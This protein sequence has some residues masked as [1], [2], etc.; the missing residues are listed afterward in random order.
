MSPHV[1]L[2]GILRP[3]LTQNFVSFQTLVRLSLFH[4]PDGD[5]P[6]VFP[7]PAEDVPILGGAERRHLVAV[8]VQLLQ[9]L[10]ALCVQDVNLP[11][12]GTAAHAAD[13]HL[14]KNQSLYLP[15]CWPDVCFVSECLR[16]WF[17]TLIKQWQ[18]AQSGR[19]MR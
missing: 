16:T 15:N 13:P 17:L 12:G 1:N 4:L 3:F 18:A 10:V 8:A 7:G 19:T 9:D 11:F 14:Q 6:V 5:F 2:Q